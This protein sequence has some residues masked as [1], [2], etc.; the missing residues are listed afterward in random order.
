MNQFDSANYPTTEP[1]KL[2]AGDRWAWKRSNLG[3]DYPPATYTL[4]YSLRL[5]GAGTE[6]EIIATGSGADFLVEVSAATTAGYTAGRY[7]FQAYITATADA[8]KRLTLGT[9]IIDV[10]ANRDTATGDPRSYARITLDAI[11]AVLQGRASKDQEEYAISSGSSS[12]SLKRTP[13][14]D[15]L[16]L[17]DRFREEVRIE[18]N[19]ERIAQGLG[20]GRRIGIR[21]RRV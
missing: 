19:A 16:V 15:L 21:L 18:V 13:M 4:K 7:R 3:S 8:T 12:R 9:G 20:D 6:I 11:E 10:A 14:A 17:R 2:V 1:T 5:E